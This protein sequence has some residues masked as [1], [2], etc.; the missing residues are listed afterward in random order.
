MASSQ[1]VRPFSHYAKLVVS[2]T[3]QGIYKNQP[4]NT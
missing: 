2:I 4:M 1:M 3:G